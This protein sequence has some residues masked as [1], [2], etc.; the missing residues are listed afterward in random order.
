MGTS[1]GAT[2]LAGGVV[3]QVTGVDGAYRFNE[4]P[5]AYMA[6]DGTHYLAAYR[7][8]LKE[9]IVED[10]GT[11]DVADDDIHW[12]LTRYH[13]QDDQ[14]ADA[15]AENEDGNGSATG[16]A[17][18]GREE[19]TD[20][21][22]TT[23]L[24][25]RANKGQIILA[26]IADEV[27][28]TY[29]TVTKAT[30]K[31]E[32]QVALPASEVAVGLEDLSGYG[33]VLQFDWLTARE[34]TMGEKDLDDKFI[35]RIIDGGD[36]GMLPPPVQ[37]VVGVVWTDT[38][39]DGIQN[40]VPVLDADGNP[41]VDSLGNPVMEMEKG[42][43]GIRVTLERY[44]PNITYAADGSGEIVAV[45]GWVKDPAWDD[46][47]HTWED[48]EADNTG[49]MSLIEGRSQLTS[50][51]ESAEGVVEDGVYRFDNLST[52][53]RDQYGNPIIYA[54]RV[55]AT[56]PA[57]KRNAYMIAKY[58]RGD[59]FTLDSNFKLKDAYL[60]KNAATNAEG[61]DEYD[62]LL[63]TYEEGVSNM[64]TWWRRRL[65]TTRTRTRGWG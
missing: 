9:T 54:Y 10:A 27:F 4:L 26:D 53:T 61:I 12:L 38:N 23:H 64:R 16:I 41:T 33:D 17:I 13:A 1:H 52:Q 20:A 34:G 22:G 5:V 18:Q 32:S 49:G 62:V 36:A 35:E 21:S 42:A 7:V 51:Q 65:P 2:A 19:F 14:L 6:P 15:D 46:D 25:T 55:R 40:E 60:M 8:A 3:A 58:L 28:T 45:N 57:F 30:L 47:T 63:N 59:D 11:P 24:L 37:S 43:N 31:Q 56:D 44:I 50:A 48:Y 39:N 29:N